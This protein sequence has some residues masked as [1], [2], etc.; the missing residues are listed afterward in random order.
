LIHFG[1]QGIEI[2]RIWARAS[3]VPGIRLC[4]ILG[5]KELG[6]VNSEQLGFVLE[7]DPERAT[8]PLTKEGLQKYCDALA[9]AKDKKPVAS[10]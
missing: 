10:H 1:R 7:I 2:N 9:K 5:F 8:K 3:T 6:Y 4:Q